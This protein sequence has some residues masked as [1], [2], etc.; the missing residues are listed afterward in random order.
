MLHQIRKMVSLAVAT[1]RGDVPADAL[2]VALSERR[3]SQP[4]PLAPTCALTL[5]RPPARV[6][7]CIWQ[8]GRCVRDARGRGHCMRGGRWGASAVSRAHAWCSS[9][10]RSVF[11]REPTTVNLN[12]YGV[13]ARCEPALFVMPLA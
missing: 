2:D 3:V 11:L 12:G 7:R 4:I 10:E 9:E 1:F 13:P 5:R 6:A 8:C